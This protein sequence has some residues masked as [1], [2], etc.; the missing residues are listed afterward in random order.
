MWYELEEGCRVFR[1]NVGYGICFSK[2]LIERQK[3]FV[4]EGSR[5]FDMKRCGLSAIRYDMYGNKAI[6]T[7]KADDY[8]WTLPIPAS[9]YRYNTL[10]EQNEG[11]PKLAV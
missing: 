10:V 3:E 8:R 6:G 9:E 5:Y 1:T 2:I 11:W 4:G 7:V